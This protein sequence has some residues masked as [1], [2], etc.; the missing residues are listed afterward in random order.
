LLKEEQR[1]AKGWCYEPAT[2]YEENSKAK[3]T[4]SH[5]EVSRPYQYKSAV[6]PQA[7]PE[8]VMTD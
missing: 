1:L 7:M 3:A 6:H 8:T 4:R 2:F 5:T